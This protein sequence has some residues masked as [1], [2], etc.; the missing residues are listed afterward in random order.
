VSLHTIGAL[1]GHTQPQTTY[2]YA[3]LFD[4]PLRKATERA[5]A[6]LAP[7]TKSEGQSHKV[8]GT[9]RKIAARDGGVACRR[10]RR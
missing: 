5:G 7:K 1:L 10:N 3:H 4:D 9:S 2:R 6:I 8:S